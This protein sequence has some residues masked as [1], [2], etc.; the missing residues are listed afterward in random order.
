M[1]EKLKQSHPW[2]YE[3]MEWA[4]L[5]LSAAAFILALAVY[6]QKG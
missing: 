2:L 5:G 1:W 3:A 4:G 6:L